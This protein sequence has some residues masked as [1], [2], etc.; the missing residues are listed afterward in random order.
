MKRLGYL[1]LLL[2][3]AYLPSG[4]RIRA[5]EA[6]PTY[7]WV[8]AHYFVGYADGGAGIAF[9]PIRDIAV[10][11]LGY[12]ATEMSNEPVRVI[13]QD[14]NDV[15]FGSVVVTTNSPLFNWSR[16][17]PIPPTILRAGVTYYLS[18]DNAEDDVWTGYVIYGSTD[19]G[20]PVFTVSADLN[21]L[22]MVAS[23]NLDGTFPKSFFTNSYWPISANFQYVTGQL[24]VLGGLQVQA[25]QVQL[26]ISVG[27][28]TPS[29]LTLLEAE[30][31]SGPWTTNLNASVVTNVPG[32]SYTLTA[33]AT[34]G[35][36]FYRVRTP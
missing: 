31:P 6:I 3:V 25:N 30:E 20:S 32:V 18:G 7:T 24:V 34:A 5:A 2:G 10:T 29:S 15:V 23:T 36:H 35:S 14:T 8:G 21:Y 19:S 11:Q 9:A 12:A 1:G 17:E 4:V 33:T 16:Y 27:G 22:A 26:G 28:G 13:L